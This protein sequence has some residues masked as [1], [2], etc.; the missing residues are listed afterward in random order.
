VILSAQSLSKNYGS[1]RHPAVR[2]VTLELQPGDFVSIVGRS[3]S[4][5]STLLAML[6]ALTRPSE[7]R[8]LFE[9]TDLWA[10]SEVELA[11]FRSCYIGFIFQFRASYRV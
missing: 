11:A 9:G 1:G 5:K 4:G 7:G 3:G 8:V 10:L 6:G 2:G